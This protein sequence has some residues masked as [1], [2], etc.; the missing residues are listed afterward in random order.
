M[1]LSARIT[2]CRIWKEPFRTLEGLNRL[3]WRYGRSPT[4]PLWVFGWTTDD[5]VRESLSVAAGAHF[6]EGAKP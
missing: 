4:E 1:E 2:R 5:Q 3:G 6:G